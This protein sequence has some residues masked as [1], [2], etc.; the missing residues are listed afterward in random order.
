MVVVVV[1]VE[2]VVITM[3]VNAA[4][5]WPRKFCLLIDLRSP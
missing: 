1:V 2:V 3:H 5:G 4:V